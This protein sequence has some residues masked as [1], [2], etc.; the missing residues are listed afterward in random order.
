[1]PRDTEAAVTAAP[2]IGIS[3]TMNLGGDRQMVLQTFFPQEGSDA[4]ANALTDRLVGIA[5]RQKARC[6][7][8]DLQAELTKHE[9]TLAQFLEDLARIDHE[10]TKKQAERAVEIE[11]LVAQ[12]KDVFEAAYAAHTKSGRSAQAFEPKGATA[13]RLRAHDGAIAKIKT[14]MEKAEA[15]RAVAVQNLQISINRY[16]DEIG[17]LNRDIDKRRLL[18]GEAAAN[19]G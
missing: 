12:R 18:L 2:A 16:G 19:E 17:R 14:E 15:E 4:E 11:T 5:E 3:V 8:P 9:R 6:D 10:H 13:S 7:I 1:M